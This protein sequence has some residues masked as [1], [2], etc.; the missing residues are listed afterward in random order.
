V[1]F[2]R[3]AWLLVLVALP[4]LWWLHRRR[5]AARIVRV[6]SLL[7]FP[8]LDATASSHAPRRRTD[9]VLALALSA[10]TALAFGAASPRI[11]THD[12]GSVYVVVDV[13]ASMSAA[14]CDAPLRAAR[15]LG[16]AAP[17]ALCD[18]HTLPGPDQARRVAAGQALESAPRPTQPDGLPASIATHLEAARAAGHPGILLV[19][20]RDVGALPGVVVVG[21]SPSG[22]ANVAVTD[23]FLDGDR[24]RFTIRNFGHRDVDVAVETAPPSGARAAR[25]A[26]RA[27]ATVDVA[28][29]R[30]GESLTVRVVAPAGERLAADDALTVRREGGVRR[31]RLDAAAACPRLAAALRA[32]GAEVATDGEVDATVTYRRAPDAAG[33]ARVLHVAPVA[34]AGRGGLALDPAAAGPVA[35]ASVAGRP[36]DGP[37]PPSPACSLAAVGRLTGGEALWT[38]GA[39]CLAA[40]LAGEVALALDPE[41]GRSDWH[42]DPSFPVAVAACLDLLAGGPDRLRAVDAVPA[43]ESDLSAPQPPTPSPR[44]VRRVVREWAAGAGGE[45]LSTALCLLAA[46]LCGAAAWRGRRAA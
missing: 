42:R 13:S 6:A 26:A 9:V 29:P 33:R 25:V 2:D 39:G 12:A 5:A 31:V 43:S 3:P 11:G 34:G 44:D 16:A 35:G 4:L 36:G 8:A 17:G 45:G 27:D 22:D 40:V 18:V 24:A 38:D 32:A 15:I 14:G 1:S 19:T 20:D 21:P 30:P 23:A 41:D 46:L 37:P 7:P 10:A 28:A